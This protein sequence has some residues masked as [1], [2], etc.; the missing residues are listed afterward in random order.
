M[1]SEKWSNKNWLQTTATDMHKP[2]SRSNFSD[3]ILKLIAA[4]FEL[5]VQCS[6]RV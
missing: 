2:E 6:L 1:K 4:I 5:Q 3:Q